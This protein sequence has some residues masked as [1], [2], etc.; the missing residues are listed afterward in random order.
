MNDGLKFAALSQLERFQHCNSFNCFNV[1]QSNQIENLAHR[2]S[3]ETLPCNGQLL[4]W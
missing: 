4:N 3:F 1:I 2:C